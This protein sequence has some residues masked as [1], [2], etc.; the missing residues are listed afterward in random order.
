MV[1]R[2]VKLSNRCVAELTGK[3][4]VVADFDPF[5]N[6]GGPAAWDPEHADDSKTRA[7]E[8]LKNAGEA[9]G[10]EPSD[11]GDGSEAEPSPDF[12]SDGDNA[13]DPDD[14]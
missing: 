1:R 10:A 3:E 9:P 5:A 11:F 4:P 2:P 6:Q 14:D 8:L 7:D 12:D 13:E